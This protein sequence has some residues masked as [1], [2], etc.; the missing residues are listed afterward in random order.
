MQDLVSPCFLVILGSLFPSCRFQNDDQREERE[1][2][3]GFLLLIHIK[4]PYHSL[5]ID[6]DKWSKIESTDINR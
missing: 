1:E 4:C 3:E 5:Y 6:D 2:R